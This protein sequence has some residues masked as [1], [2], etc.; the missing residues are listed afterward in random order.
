M[1]AVETM[2]L[3]QTGRIF[4]NASN[5][6]IGVKSEASYLWSASDQRF[7]TSGELWARQQHGM[8]C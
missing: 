6:N 8:S 4:S 2:H 7:F 1:T 5:M 3:V